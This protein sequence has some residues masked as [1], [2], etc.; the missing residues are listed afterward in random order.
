MVTH[1]QKWGNSLA[2]RI[3]K[4]IATEVK[5]NP[6]TEVKLLLVGK[7]LTIFPVGVSKFSLRYLVSKITKKNCHREIDTG[8]PVG[9]EI[10]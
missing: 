9:N 10:W 7:K 3:P 4:L 1:I 6:G 2:I 5:L 8:Q